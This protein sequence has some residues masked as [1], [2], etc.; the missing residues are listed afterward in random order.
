MQLSPG[1]GCNSVLSCLLINATSAGVTVLSCLFPCASA[2][3]GTWSAAGT[4]SAFG[5]SAGHPL[6]EERT[7]PSVRAS[8]TATLGCAVLFRKVQRFAFLSRSFYHAGVLIFSSFAQ[9]M[10]LHL[11]RINRSFSLGIWSALHYKTL[12]E[13]GVRNI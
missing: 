9:V 13:L 11:Y 1:P 5:A 7:A 8:T 4:S 2:A 6:P 12:I 10:W 3:P